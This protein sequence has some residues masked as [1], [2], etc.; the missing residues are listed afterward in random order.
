[1]LF[2]RRSIGQRGFFLSYKKKKKK[3]T[4]EAMGEGEEEA[5]NI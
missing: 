4:K 3:E 2:R 5:K 1:M